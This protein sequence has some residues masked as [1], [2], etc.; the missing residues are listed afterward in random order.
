MQALINTTDAQQ[1]EIADMNSA[2]VAANGQSDN[3][4]GIVGL[5]KQVAGLQ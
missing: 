2:A 3:S 4:K 1:K 5:T